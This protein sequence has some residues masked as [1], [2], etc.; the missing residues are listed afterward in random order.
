MEDEL[1]AIWEGD[2]ISEEGDKDATPKRLREIQQIKSHQL[3]D[4]V[5]CSSRVES[6]DSVGRSE[7]VEL[8][9]VGFGRV[10]TVRSGQVWS[11]M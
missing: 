10:H 9:T 5:V 4:H 1:W 6:E 3:G 8:A 11:G 7:K 2:G